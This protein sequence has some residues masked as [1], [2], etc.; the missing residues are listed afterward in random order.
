VCSAWLKHHLPCC[1]RAIWRVPPSR[2]SEAKRRKVVIMTAGMTLC[3]VAP[4]GSP[5]F[6]KRAGGSRSLPHAGRWEKT[7]SPARTRGSAAHFT[8]GT[9]D[10][11]RRSA[12]DFRRWCF[13][14]NPSVQQPAERRTSLSNPRN[15]WSKPFQ[16]MARRRPAKSSQKSMILRLAPQRS[17]TCELWI[18]ESFSPGG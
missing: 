14:S 17:K 4:D 18:P 8:D 16:R 11:W 12:C 9:D 7:A 2:H 15:P 5:A 1:A 10:E 6:R 13:V 3:C